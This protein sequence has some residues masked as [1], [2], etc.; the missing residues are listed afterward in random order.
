VFSVV[1]IAATAETGAVYF[2][3]YVHEPQ[4][5]V[6]SD[7]DLADITRWLATH[8][9]DGVPVYLAALHYRHPTVAALSENFDEVKWIAGN[10]GI[11]LPNG[12][13]YLFFARLGLPDEAWLRKVLP[14][15][16]L[17]DKPL[18]PDGGTNYRLYHLDSQPVIS[19]QVT[20]R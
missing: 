20:Q 7:G 14:D 5:Y 17:I 18:A 2:G 11:V 12:P 1:L 15:A 4:L 6:Q 10:R 19:P 16:A 9:T 8:H 13:G 3:Q